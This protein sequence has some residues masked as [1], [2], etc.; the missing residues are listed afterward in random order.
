MIAQPHV[1]ITLSTNCKYLY[2][3]LSLLLLFPDTEQ[4]EVRAT[5][6][7][8]FAA[9]VLQYM[10]RSACIHRT[11]NQWVELPLPLN[12]RFSGERAEIGDTSKRRG[13]KMKI[14]TIKYKQYQQ[15]YQTSKK[16]IYKKN[17]TKK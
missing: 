16:E 2:L 15:S 9:Q 7:V 1:L 4:K 13:D 5:E 14:L 12:S 11:L 6:F 10:D 3:L 8:E 17:L